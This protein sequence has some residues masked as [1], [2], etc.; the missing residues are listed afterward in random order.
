MPTYTAR[1]TLCLLVHKCRQ[2]QQALFKTVIILKQVIA[3]FASI[4][5][6]WSPS[7]R[8]A[9]SLIYGESESVAMFV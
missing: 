5:L 6:T 8:N 3:W 4:V 9:S 7:G 1:C 2:K